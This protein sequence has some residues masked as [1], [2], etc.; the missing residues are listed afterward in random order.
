MLL[1]LGA[2]DQSSP[3]MGRRMFECKT[4]SRRFPSFQALGG[5]RASHKKMRTD[6][7]PPA[8][9]EAKEGKT[10]V[11]EC[12]ICG[13]EF[14]IGQALGGHMRRHR[15]AAAAV[16]GVAERKG[17]EEG[18][19]RMWMD[20]NLTPMENDLVMRKISGI[21]DWIPIVDCFN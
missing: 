14:G 21:G 15:A 9:G 5:H 17:G 18:R 11:H 8:E 3:A 19:R 10:R 13:L 20:L 6:G 1:S 12:S 16:V 2:G 7:P 4:C